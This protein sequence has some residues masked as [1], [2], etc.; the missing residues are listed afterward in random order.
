M[1]NRTSKQ[2]KLEGYAHLAKT[3]MKL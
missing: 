3:K 1:N 2:C